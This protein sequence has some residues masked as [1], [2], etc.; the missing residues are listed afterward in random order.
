MENGNVLTFVGRKEDEEIPKI[1]V[2]G[3]TVETVATGGHKTF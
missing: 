3:Y 2:C 1:N